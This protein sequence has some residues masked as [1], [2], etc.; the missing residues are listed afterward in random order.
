[1]Y[2]IG[3]VKE[4]LGFE[5]TIY[6]E[7]I[8]STNVLSGK[9]ARAGKDNFLIIAK[10]QT[11]G[12]GR[13]NRKW[14]S[15]EG[16]IYFSFAL[17]STKLPFSPQLFSIASSI[18]VM[19]FLNEQQVQNVE[20]RWPN[21]I[22]VNGKKICGI[23]CE[24][25]DNIVIA[26]IGFNLNNEVFDE[27]IEKIATS[28]YLEKK[29]THKEEYALLEIMLSILKTASDK[30]KISQFLKDNPMK[31]KRILVKTGEKSFSGIVMG[32]KETGEIEIETADGKMQFFAGDIEI[33]R[34]E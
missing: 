27:E 18:G 33:L 25:V 19:N 34:G 17:N 12:K 8:D 32:F 2:N 21:D 6:F 15:P 11:G 29:M 31:G 10:T 16:G 20:Y 9:M 5:D 30:E 23:L 24:L 28:L 22:L 7:T 14:Y 13:H 26:G 3:N 4:I 1:M